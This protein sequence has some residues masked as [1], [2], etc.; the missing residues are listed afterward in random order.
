MTSH[1][2]RRFASLA[3]LIVLAGTSYFLVATSYE[4]AQP[5]LP[6][7]P[8][9]CNHATETLTF[10]VTGTC[11]PE[12]SITVISPMD[13]CAV[14]VTGASAVGLPSA[15]RFDGTDD[16]VVSLARS[17]WSLSGYLPESQVWAGPQADAGPFTVVGRD[18]QA[19]KDPSGSSAAA[20]QHNTPLVRTCS[21][22]AGS[23][24][25]VPSIL[26]CSGG[27]APDCQAALQLL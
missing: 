23:S 7:A 18:A 12:G 6:N 2:R 14:A 13:E 22:Q 15:G 25:S 26:K 24:T 20:D 27:G 9:T 10:Q 19:G 1:L 11:G 5:P 17:P 8:K 3:R 21:Y 16:G 4:P